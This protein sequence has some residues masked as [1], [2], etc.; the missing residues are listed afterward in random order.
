MQ[1]F[2]FTLYKMAKHTPRA[3]MARGVCPFSL[4]FSYSPST[5]LKLST[6]QAVVLK[7]SVPLNVPSS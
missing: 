2:F 7:L 5:T 3:H 6:P 1:A 4:R